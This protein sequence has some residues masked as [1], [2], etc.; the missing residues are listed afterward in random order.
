MS[1]SP[2]S[3]SPIPITVI[4]GFLG[5]G[6]TTLLSSLV[7]QKDMKNSAVII[8][9]FGEIGLDHALIEQT[10]ETIIELQ[11]GC[12]CCTIRGDLHKTLIE[13][14]TKSKQKQISTFDRVVIETTGLADPTPIIHTLMTSP[15]LHE[16]YTLDGVITL[17]DAVNGEQT[18]D[19]QPESV[20][21]AALAER[22]IL[23]KTDLADAKTQS[24]LLARLKELNP[25]A[26][27]LH[28]E[29]GVIDAHKLLNIGSYD[30]FNKS[31]DV[32]E[33]LA[34]EAHEDSHKHSH[35]HNHDHGTHHHH[36]DVNRH[37][38]SIQAFTMSSD[39]PV[40]FMAFGIF[41]DMLSAQ[42]GPDLLRVKGIINIAD[43]K[44]PAI[45]HGVQHI[46]HPVKW[47]DQWPDEDRRTR[48]VFITRN[49]KKEVIEKFFH[50]LMEAVNETEKPVQLNS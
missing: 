9:E 38:E 30:I 16:I 22:I 39:K 31:H 29:N 50:C 28:I 11:S 45:I 18:L 2:N 15:D 49:I 24:S 1:T 34:A 12:I 40:N 23:S 7:K 48:L 17:V 37:D 32:K 36:H 41:L 35:T 8:N 46:F 21:Q 25:S 14:I 19:A 44:R 47:L 27:I 5:S 42:V 20:K 33:W 26:E 10:D 3:T 43:D 6:K 4:T 13:L